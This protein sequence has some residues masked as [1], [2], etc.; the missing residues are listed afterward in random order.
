MVSLYK[1]LISS[2]LLQGH[3]LVLNAIYYPLEKQFVF[4]YTA[5]NQIQHLKSLMKKKQDIESRMLQILLSIR[6]NCLINTFGK[7]PLD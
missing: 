3:R 4:L 2:L 6:N 1:E 7:I 5:Q